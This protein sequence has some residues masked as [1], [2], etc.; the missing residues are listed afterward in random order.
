M[1]DNVDRIEVQK[2]IELGK[3]RGYLTYDEVNNSL[4]QDILA[5]DAMADTLDDM[6]VRFKEVG[7]RECRPL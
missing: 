6:I 7:I 2:L 5:G 3:E 4:P 1:S